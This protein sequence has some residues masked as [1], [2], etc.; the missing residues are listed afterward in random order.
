MK[1]DRDAANREEGAFQDVGCGVLKRTEQRQHGMK[2]VS[3]NFGPQAKSRQSPV[4]IN[5]VLLE[6]R[7]TH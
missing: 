1:T 7:H 6:K 3:A 5:K 2:Q 4:S